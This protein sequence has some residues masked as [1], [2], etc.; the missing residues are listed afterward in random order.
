[1]EGD[2]C[3]PEREERLT[4]YPPPNDLAWKGFLIHLRYAAKQYRPVG[5]VQSS[6]NPKNFFYQTT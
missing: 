4:Y 3:T 1:M 5:S 6:M 2:D